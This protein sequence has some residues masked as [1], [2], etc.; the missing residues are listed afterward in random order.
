MK[1]ILPIILTSLLLILLI[2]ACQPSYKGH[3][4]EYIKIEGVIIEIDHKKEYIVV[5]YTKNKKE[6]TVRIN[7][8]NKNIEDLKQGSNVKAEV[9]F[10][11]EAIAF[12]EGFPVKNIHKIN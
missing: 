6:N 10:P 12:T 9:F 8:R 1:K 3:K 4:G 5:K 7:T 11:N 2:T